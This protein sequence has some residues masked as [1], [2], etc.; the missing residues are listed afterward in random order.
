MTLI[1]REQFLWNFI[2]GKLPE[3][4]NSISIDEK[5]YINDSSN[6]SNS[7]S[8]I[9]IS[10]IPTYINASLKNKENYNLIRIPHY[11]DKM[12]GV[13]IVFDAS[14]T[15][16]TFLK[17]HVKKSFQKTLRR[18]VRRLELSFNISYEYHYGNIS[19]EEYDFLLNQIH[20]MLIKRFQEIDEINFYIEEWDLNTSDLKALINQKKAA[21]FVI[22]NENTPISI[23]VHRIVGEHFLFSECHAFNTDYSKFGIGHIDNYLIVNWCIKN[24]IHFVDLGLGNTP[25]KT[26]WSNKPYEIEYQIYY[27]KNALLARVLA[28]KEA[29]IIRQKNFIKKNIIPRIKKTQEPNAKPKKADF[30]V[31]NITKLPNTKELTTIYNKEINELGLNRFV[32]DFLYSNE[33]YVNNVKVFKMN[34]ET[35]YLK[36]EKSLQ[37]ITKNNSL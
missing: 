8:V 12:H 26:V 7:D 18:Y 37:E 35:F 11:S 33:E 22:K 31:T 17:D 32:Y 36:G 23:S 9:Y 20:E 13:G 28:Y 15:Y 30:N 34:D 10:V 29:F 16:E 25:Y 1:K 3:S 2:K 14:H 24:D 6:K 19:D 4:F 27:K 5:E 21:F